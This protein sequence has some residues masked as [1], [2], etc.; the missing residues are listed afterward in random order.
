MFDV[1]LKPSYSQFGEDRI[2]ETL[3][4]TSTPG[5]FVDVGCNHPQEFSNTFLLYRRG[6]TGVDVDANASFAPLY[7]RMRPR[8]TFVHS[9]ISNSEEPV[10]F[11]EFADSLVSSASPEHVEA[12]KAMRHVAR[13]VTMEPRSL[14]S[15][16]QAHAFPSRFELLCVDAEGSDLAVLESLDFKLFRPQ[17]VVV[18]M[19]KFSIETPQADPIYGLLAGLGYDMV[20]Y[21]MFNGFFLS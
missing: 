5:T 2:I 14:T 1:H 19:H 21:S 9:L 6:W 3:L 11:T 8:D 16:L 4:D 17:L 10:T 13:E 20:G 18:E 15:V 12:W 7:E